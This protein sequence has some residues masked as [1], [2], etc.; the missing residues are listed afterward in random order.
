MISFNLRSYHA[1][2]PR[3]L[4]DDQ[5]CIVNR[6]RTARDPECLTFGFDKTVLLF[7][8]VDPDLRAFLI[9]DTD[10]DGGVSEVA[11][12]TEPSLRYSCDATE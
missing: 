11:F 12:F 3:D 1:A 5:I 9:A 10:A 7:G 8:T 4:N 6:H 2:V